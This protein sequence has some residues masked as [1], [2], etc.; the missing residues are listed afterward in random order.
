MAVVST[1][2]ADAPKLIPASL[3]SSFLW[4]RLHSLSGI[5]PVGLFLLFHMFE[6][7]KALDGA[8]AYNETVEHINSML[9][10]PYFYLLELVGLI[11]PILFHSFYGVYIV[12]SGKTNTERYPYKSNILYGLQRSSGIIAFLFIAYHVASLRVGVTLASGVLVSYGDVVNHLA[13]WWVT[14]IYLIGVLSTEF[15]FANGLNGFCWSWGIAV[16]DRGRALVEWVAWGL[17]LVMAIPSVHL[18]LFLHSKS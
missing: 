17:L 1:H 12:F 16:S 9:P 13:P 18:I 3:D 10:K 14:A 2:E 8:P 6:N 7:A 11:G 5:A 4:R 15:H